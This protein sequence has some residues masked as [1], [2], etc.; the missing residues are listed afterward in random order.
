MH[1]Q[2][3]TEIIDY[4]H[5]ACPDLSIALTGSVANGSYNENSDI[6]ILVSHKDFTNSYYVYGYYKDIKIGIFSYHKKIFWQKSLDL[7]YYYQNL[8]IGYIYYSQIIYDSDKLIIDLKDRIDDLLLRKKLLKKTLISDL[9]SEI[10]ELLSNRK[11]DCIEHKES[12]Y[13]ILNNIISIFFLKEYSSKILTKKEAIDPYSIIKEKDIELYNILRA[14]YPCH[15]NSF[16]LIQ[17][18]IDSYIFINY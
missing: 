14:C 2:V 3:A 11:S 10:K 1:K 7:L 4:L 5:S 9:K 12:L 17:K 18:A 16:K 8:R 15:Q 6:D 13:A